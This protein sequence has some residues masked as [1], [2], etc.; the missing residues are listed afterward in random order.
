MSANSNDRGTIAV[1]FV[2]EAQAGVRARGFDANLLLRES[3][4]PPELLQSSQARVSSSQYG[5]KS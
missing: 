1:C 3:G 4:I 5:K 2:Q